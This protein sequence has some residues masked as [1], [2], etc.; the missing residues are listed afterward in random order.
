MTRIVSFLGVVGCALACPRGPGPCAVPDTQRQNR[1]SKPRRS[2]CR[3]RS[4]PRLALDSRSC[5]RSRSLKGTIRGV[6][7]NMKSLLSTFLLDAFHDVTLA[8]EPLTIDTFVRAER[9]L[10]P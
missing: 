4:G 9:G 8:S 10:S 7:A 3:S 2:L 5:S 6:L 1:P